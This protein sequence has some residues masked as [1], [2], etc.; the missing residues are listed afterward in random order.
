MP[1]ATCCIL[2]CQLIAF[3][4]KRLLQDWRGNYDNFPPEYP[5]PPPD[6]DEYIDDLIAEVKEAEDALESSKIDLIEGPGNYDGLGKPGRRQGG[7][8]YGQPEYVEVW[9]EKVDLVDIFETL[10]MPFGV[11][12]RGNGGYP[13]LIF[14]NR[15]CEELKGL[16]FA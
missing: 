11:K 6:P 5:T 4:T 16:M 12:V 15:C 14:L 2:N 8:W 10:V 7:R 3:L 13:S 1:M 9:E